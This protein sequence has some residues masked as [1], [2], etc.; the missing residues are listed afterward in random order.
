[1][2]QSISIHNV[3]LIDK[4]AL[5]FD[6]SLSVFTGETGAGKSILLDALS[7]VLGARADTGLVRHGQENLSVTAEFSISEQHKAYALLQE[8]EL[9][10]DTTL[11]LRRSLTKD[12]KSKAFIN[13]VPVSAN[14]L[15]QFGDTLVEIHGQFATHSLL[16]SATHLGVLDKYGQLECFVDE[17]KKCY[18]IWKQAQKNVQDA[19]EILQKAKLDEDFL[20]HAV[21]ELRAFNPV[22]GEEE[23]LSEKRISLMNA[24]KITES[25]NN[26]Y[27]ILSTGTNASLQT[28][29]TT[30]I[31]Q[32]EKAS[33]FME[34]RFDSV[35]ARL[36]IASEE[37]AQA[38][39]E[40]EN[41]AS[42]FEDPAG[43]LEKVDE[44]FFALKDLARKYQVDCDD[45]PKT[46]LDFEEKLSLIGNGEEELL[47]LRQKEEQARLDFIKIAT[48]L[49][50]KR[51]EVAKKLDEAVCL[52]L[53]ALKLE[54]AKFITQVDDLTE[55]NYTSNGMNNVVFC[56]STNGSA[57][58][59]PLNKIAS[60][61]EL[62]RFMLALKVN[63]AGLEDIPT[64]VFDEVDSGI[65]GATASA[66]GERL[67]R[68]AK[69]KQ[70]LVVTHSPQV[71]AFASTH[72]KVE[73]FNDKDA[74]LTTVTALQETERLEEIARM[75]SGAQ[76]TEAARIAARTLWEKSCF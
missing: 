10:T 40:L 36:D 33:R 29:I 68:L 42:S 62:A 75:L 34:G 45:L 16:N 4:L 59:A 3:V 74:V 71:A 43:E 35:L 32:L 22:Q 70:V 20:M 37:L 53:P 11:I 24:E 18:Q 28:Q 57:T 30:A 72:M 73:K 19:L 38:S 66:V 50:Q 55:E 69:E 56:I 23:A 9:D 6:K 67:A 5:S 58:P 44:R 46:L 2:L 61:G 13:D 60:G 47:S 65:G 48:Q 21:K 41:I 51:H 15:R 27:Q 8:N 12:G 54:K 7:F 63:L 17:C 14:L 31:R 52:E 49:S 39:D 76:V 1:M 64:L 26:A 25:L